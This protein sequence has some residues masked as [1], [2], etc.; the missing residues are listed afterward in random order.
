MKKISVLSVFLA[1]ASTVS[2]QY[3]IVGKDSISLAD[4]KKEY[5]YGLENNGVEKTIK[6]TQDFILLQQFAQEKKADT[7]AAFRESMYRKEGELR[8]DF[9]YPKEV[10]EPVLQDFV[11][12]SKNE[13]Q[14][15]LFMVEKTDGDT[16]DYQQIY[17]DVKSGKITM[18]DAIAKYTKS[19]A[20]PFYIKPGTI[21][22]SIYQQILKLPNGSYSTLTNNSSFA[23]FAKVLNTRPSLGYMIFGTISYPN[24]ANAE[25]TKTKI[26][27]ELKEGKKFEDVAKTYGSNDREKN[28]AGVVLGSPTL[29]DDV[30]NALKGQKRG[31][32][33][34]PILIGD[35]Y[36]VF[37]IYQLYPYVLDKDNHDFFFGEMQNTL[38]A[39]VLEDKLLA[40]IKAQPGFKEMPLTKELAKSYA[41]FSAYT[42]EADVLYQFNNIK[43]TVGD[44]KKIIKDHTEEA[45]KFSPEQWSTVFNNFEEQNLKKAYTI[46]FVNRK[47]IRK[48]LDDTRKSLF[49][50]YVFSKYL[51]EEIDQH[52]EWLTE[53]YNANK[54]KYMWGNRAKGRVAIIAD[55]KLVSEI[56]KQ[57]KD[58]KNWEELKKKYYGKLNADNQILVHFEEGEMAEDADV[59]NKYKVP[60]KKGIHATK[61]EKR[62]LVIAIDDLLPPTQMTQEEAADLLKDAV[63][64]QKL[65]E[66][67]EQQRAK[68]QITVQPQFL[69][70]LQKNFKK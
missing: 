40:Y 31:F 48:Q 43:T 3:M 2:A 46:D 58:P 65:N 8:K 11:N 67:I 51:R 54:S 44:I 33:P 63:T 14:I 53:Y 28:N 21:D 70:D 36:F 1:F 60:F 25:A 47:D 61:M 6:S 38:Y 27:A 24:D 41:A 39:E 9:F 59:F 20:E 26:Y 49:S 64:D 7:T 68:T 34:Q 30:Y 62:D 4:F 15:Q 16:N 35:K 12:L 66:T 45:A 69:S 56:Q 13:Q 50:D 17:N 42:K 32:Y 37:Y 52:P 19:S 57:M 55:P 22:N 18:E 23:A 5:A 10:A 29:P